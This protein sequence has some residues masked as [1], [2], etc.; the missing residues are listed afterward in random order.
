M[1]SISVDQARAIDRDAVERLGM[2]S[3][4]LM[5][6]AS[7]AV[8]EIR[9]TVCRVERAGARARSGAARASE[10]VTV[11]DHGVVRSRAS[12]RV[13][14]GDVGNRGSG[15]RRGVGTGTGEKCSRYE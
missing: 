13:D 7:R 2:P 1:Q 15:G 12:D 6:N 8:A 10:P 3:I 11:E 4:L 5:E 9:R 14:H